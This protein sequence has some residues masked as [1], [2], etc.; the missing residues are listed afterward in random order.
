MGG[1]GRNT[2]RG[3]STACGHRSRFAPEQHSE[4]CT[5][6]A[7]PEQET[8]HQYSSRLINMRLQKARLKPSAGRV[9]PLLSIA[10][11]ECLHTMGFHSRRAQRLDA[12]MVS[13]SLYQHDSI[14]WGMGDNRATLVHGSPIARGCAGGAV[15]HPHPSPGEVSGGDLG[16][17]A[18]QRVA[19]AQ[20][21]P[22]GPCSCHSA[23]NLGHKQV[24]DISALPPGPWIKAEH[25]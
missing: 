3:L 16:T 25:N 23:S 10:R 14:S 2:T 18:R 20:G 21:S 24:A 7:A 12:G 1:N 17:W 22:S 11:A 15:G 19:P 4:R 13:P 9:P 8:L 6:A 5:R